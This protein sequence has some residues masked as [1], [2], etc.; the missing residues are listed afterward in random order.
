M[1]EADKARQE[2]KKLEDAAR[3]EGATEADAALKAAAAHEADTRAI[4]EQTKALQEQAGASR[5]NNVQTAF[6]GRSSMDQHLQ[7]IDA[8][9]QKKELLQRTEN[10][11]FSSPQSAQAWRDQVYQKKLQ[12][13]RAAQMGYTTPDQYLNYIDQERNR[14]LAQTQALRS[15]SDAIEESTKAYTGQANAL[16]QTHET[17]AQLGHTGASNIQGYQ[18]SLAGLPADVRTRVSFDDGDALSGSIA[19]RASIASV[20]ETVTTHAR[21]DTAGVLAGVARLKTEMASVGGL[22]VIPE[23]PAEAAP[24]LLTSGGVQSAQ[25]GISRMLAAQEDER[26]QLEQQAQAGPDLQRLAQLRRPPT[27]GSLGAIPDRPAEA[28]PG[29]LTPSGVASL[30]ASASAMLAQPARVPAQAAVIP[31]AAPVRTGDTPEQA[32]VRAMLAARGNEIAPRVNPETGQALPAPPSEL[33]THVSLDDEDA[34]AKALAYKASLEAVPQAVTTRAR[35]DLGDIPEQI[36]ALRAAQATVGGLGAIPGRAEAAPGFLTPAGVAS[37]QA[38]MTA[39]L[40]DQEAARQ[41][42]LRTPQALPRLSPLPYA[43]AGFTRAVPEQPVHQD[44]AADL[45]RRLAAGEFGASARLP[46]QAEIAAHYA[47]GPS[48]VSRALGVLRDTGAVTAQGGRLAGVAQPG[49][50][51]SVAVG[52]I[53]K[54]L[55]DVQSL[56]DRL[57]ELSKEIARPDVDPSHVVASLKIIRQQVQDAQKE[58]KE[59]GIAPAAMTDVLRSLHQVQGQAG[60]A[61]PGFTA[62]RVDIGPSAAS[63]A[64]ALGRRWSSTG[65]AIS[66]A[67]RSASVSATTN[68]ERVASEGGSVAD[69][70]AGAFRGL[71]T[72]GS[73]GIGGIFANL[74]QAAASSGGQIVSSLTPMLATFTA[75]IQLLPALV[76]G[77]GTLATVFA[78]LPELVAATATAMATLK[79]AID[80]VIQALSAYGALLSAQQSL[81]ANPLQTAMQMAQQQNTLSNAYYGVQQ[82]AFQAGESQVTNAHSVADAQFALQQAVHQAAMSQV[83]DAHAVQDA[84]FS[85]GQAYFQQSITQ[86]TSAMSVAEAQHSLADA[87]FATSQAQYQLNIAWQT[88]AEDLAALEL[89]VNYASTNLRGAQLALEQAQQ[90]YAQVMANS[91]ATALDRA[92]AAYQI[93]AAEESLAEVEQQNTDNETKLADVRKYGAAQVFGVTQAEHALTDAQFSQIEAQKQLIITQKE[94]ANDQIVAAHEITDAVFALWEAQKNQANDALV[95]AHNVADAQ[96]N[97]SQAYVNQGEGYIT[98]AHDQQQAAFTLQQA[99]DQMALGLPSIASAEAN[100]ATAMYRLGPA[101]KT[102]VTYLT[103]LAAWFDTNRTVGQAFFAQLDPALRNIGSLIKPLNSYLTANAGEL[104]KLAAQ[105]VTWFDKLAHSPAWGV[106]T[107]STV[108]II[109]NMGGALGAMVK[110]FT[111]LAEVAAPFTTWLTRGIEHLADEFERWARNADKPGSDFRRWLNDVKPALD[112]VG[113]LVHAIIDG[114]KIIAGGP[115]GSPGSLSSLKTFEDIMSTLSG[116]ILP[117]FFTFIHVLSRPDIAA[118]ITNLFGALSRLLLAVVSTPGFQAGFSLMIRGFTLL[119]D[120]FADLLNMK[121]LQPVFD[122]ITLALGGLL[123]LFTVAKFTGVLSLI[124]HIRQ[125]RQ[126]A[127]NAYGALNRVFQLVTGRSLPGAGGTTAAEEKTAAAPITEAFDAGAEKVGSAIT[128]AF[129]AGAEKISGAITG[130]G[131]EAAD[132]QGAAIKAAGETAGAEEA[133]GEKLGGAEAAAEEGAGTAAGG[134]VAGA[135][136][137]AGG[138]AGAGGLA[139]M[140]GLSSLLP[141]I[142][143]II[144]GWLGAHEIESRLGPQATNT[145]GQAI[146]VNAPALSSNVQFGQWMTSFMTQV[147]TPMTKFF[148]VGLPAIAQSAFDPVSRFFGTQLPNWLSGGTTGWAGM[149]ASSENNFTSLVAP[150]GALFTTQ[151][152]DW[153]QGPGGAGGWAGLWDSVSTG[154]SQAAGDVSKFFTTSV[155]DWLQGPG[156]AG[157][158]AGLW[159]G[160]RTDWTDLVATPVSKFFTSTL[161]DFFESL[162]GKFESKVIQPLKALWNSL[163]VQTI[164]Q[165]FKTSIN[166][167]INNV[168]NKAIG[169]I[170]DVT[171]IVGIPAIHKVQTLATGGHVLGNSVSGSGDHDSVHAMLTPGEYVIRKPARMAIDAQMGPEFLHSLNAMGFA[172]GG[173]VPGSGVLKDFGSFFGSLGSLLSGGFSSILSGIEGIAGKGLETVFNAVWDRG[174]NPLV[175]DLIGGSAGSSSVVGAIT[176]GILGTIKAG[177]DKVLTQ[178]QASAPGKAGAAGGFTGTPPPGGAVQMLMQ[179]MAAERGWTGPEW[180]ALYDVEMREAG[181][182]LTAQNPSSGAYGL[183]QFIDG[184]SEYAEYGGN[185]TTA[186]GQITGML[187][188]IKCVPLDTLILT[189]EGWKTCDEVQ[190]GDETVGFDPDTGE[191]RWTPVIAVHRYAEAPLVRMKNSYGDFRSTPNHKW[192]TEKYIQDRG[193]YRRF[194]FTETQ[195]IVSRH[196]IR[197]AA[198]HAQDSGLPI[199]GAEAELLGWVAGDGHFIWRGRSP[200]VSVFQSEAKPVQLAALRRLL[201]DVPHAEYARPSASGREPIHQFRLRSAYARDLL[202]RSGYAGDLEQMVL[203]MSSSQRSAFLSGLLAADGC[204]HDGTWT[205]CQNEGPVLE[206]GMLAAYLCGSYVHLTDSG[207][208]KHAVLGRQ[209]VGHL[210]RR[211]DAGTAPVWCVTTELGSWTARQSGQ[212]FLTGNS[213]YGTP[214]AAWQSELTRGFYY[215]GGDVISSVKDATTNQKLRESMLLGAYLQTEWNPAYSSGDRHGAWGIN[216]KNVSGITETEAD[217]P[218]KAAKFML[219]YYIKGLDKYGWKQPRYDATLISGY[220]S[221]LDYTKDV[222]SI[223][224]GWADTLYAL[225]LSKTETGTGKP[226]SKTPGS[227]GND[228]AQAWNEASAALAKAVAAEQAPLLDLLD[229]VPKV[230]TTKKTTVKGKTVTTTSSKDAL[231]A[232]SLAWRQWYAMQRIIDEQSKLSTGTDAT[233]AWSKLWALQ[234]APQSMTAAQ[235]EAFDTAALDLA[236]WLSGHKPVPQSAWAYEMDDAKWPALP[237]KPPLN[238]VPGHI[239][240]S[241]SAWSKYNKDAWDKAVTAVETVTGLEPAAYDAWNALYGPQGSLTQTAG[242][243]TPG[244]AA[245]P[246]SARTVT[247]DY[248]GAI[249]ESAT[250]GGPAVPQYAGGGSV[251]SV[252]SMFAFANGGDVYGADF[253]LPAGIT[254][255]TPPRSVSEAGQA[256]GAAGSSTNM[257]FGDINIHNPLPERASDSIAHRVQRLALFAGRGPY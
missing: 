98:S 137:G 33:A 125:L 187:N 197:M 230:T 54:S 209:F 184:P 199:T 29:F 95:N 244:P 247:P 42:A 228:P 115:M 201:E 2:L 51:P 208:Q 207:G 243:P 75:V 195:K 22:G 69:R 3:S 180:T 18:A 169:F 214:E 47:A 7:D 83:E 44:I 60:R 229:S 152:P 128:E 8:E 133:A 227:G 78:S 170:N 65:S 196:R 101:A 66:D 150:I 13:N 48:V 251:G 233:S 215:T 153:L 212:V 10:M 142:A 120:I 252:A 110:G 156:G 205:L 192:L 257:S 235:W 144:A 140:L 19:Y 188:Y 181:F 5:L 219:P 173:S 12:E 123:A 122:G 105:A 240:P 77:F 186:A 20:P 97:L 103:P 237:P 28:A 217:N 222:A 171:K 32:A 167:V 27:L 211:E 43:Q 106:L 182:S 145:L 163:A 118:A 24:G 127:E 45:Q 160:V 216:L 14:I 117:S 59:L 174:V 82:A 159:R 84:Q 155:P 16:R 79:M 92:Q 256:T 253:G 223:T 26:R 135:E 149:W 255:V 38:G 31:P 245:P 25:A 164:E 136:E 62:P 143:P 126:V 168:I 39:M 172:A 166:W 138:A 88:A 132:E 86:V 183:A 68:L 40:A 224:T 102:A 124:T 55:A 104:G 30:Q 112:D 21:L 151:L 61:L 56:K 177:V 35:L 175:S 4:K 9:R 242:P 220:A 200:E 76:A 202:S 147:V 36:A 129:D 73:G 161:P 72:G 232:N 94:A 53:E 71:A 154:F 254:R 141:V 250:E 114:F 165:D 178:Q 190:P 234:D 231:A 46:T 157:G 89:Q 52:G 148:S 57:K 194:E 15:R 189:R 121:A 113:H 191:S 193:G 204:L 93:Q 63:A 50:G 87:V 23:R 37:A 238:M 81:A 91:N 109:A 176:E 239:T 225:G 74:A 108:H 221:G 130:A 34:L 90:N 226:V 96:F 203:A 100:L 119:L 249:M 41:E 179:Q 198:P 70:I 139:G 80:P 116:T 111:D 248:L 146:T 241:L 107:S 213:R 85:V 158:W 67:F 206:A 6:G 49:A 162:P 246:A 11:G 218:Y 99:L 236:Q 185:A 17:T 58:F 131:T 134:G 1:A 210:E 64:D